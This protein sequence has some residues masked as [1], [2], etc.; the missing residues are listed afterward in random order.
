[1][2]HQYIEPVSPRLLLSLWRER[3]GKTR[4]ASS[5][6]PYLRGKV[7][8]W[9]NR[10][11][12]ARIWSVPGSN[13]LVAAIC[14]LF[15]GLLLQVRMSPLGQ[16]GFSIF[17]LAV[18]LYIRRFSGTFFTLMLAAMACMVSLRYL[19]WRFSATLDTRSTADFLL[20]LGFF[21]AELYLFLLTGMHVLKGIWPLTLPQQPMP[22]DT[23]EWP[24]VDVFIVASNSSIEIAN[25]TILA[26]LAMSWPKKKM[27]V[28]V[29]DAYPRADLQSLCSS[30]EVHYFASEQPGQDRFESVNQA[31]NQSTGDF[32][33]VLDGDQ[34]PQAKLLKQTMGWLVRHQSLGMVETPD[35]FLAP[36]LDEHNRMLFNESRDRLSFSITRRSMLIAA[37]GFSSNPVT[38]QRHTALHLQ[39]LGFGCA[40][41]G[42]RAGALPPQ[43]PDADT[44]MFC[45][46][47]P[48]NSIIL[49]WQKYLNDLVAAM[50]FYYP[51]VRLVFMT[52]PV[53]YLLTG[54]HIINTASDLWALY[55]L[56]HVL[57]G[58]IA[59]ARLN[60]GSRWGLFS[61]IRETMLAWYLLLPT[62]LTF[63]RTKVHQFWSVPSQTPS[64]SVK[65]SDRILA[66]TYG[67]I[68]W[69]NLSGLVV[70]S[71]FWFNS[72]EIPNDLTS[73][74]LLWSAFNLMRLAAMLC[75]TEEASAIQKYQRACQELPVMVKL[76]YG[77][78]LSC[79]TQNF[80]N[81]QLSIQ[82]P[83][84][85]ALPLESFVQIS[86]FHRRQESS[87]PAQ[88]VSLHE[89]TLQVRIDASAQTDYNA[90]AVAV[91]SRG[92]DWPKWLPGRH[93]DQPWP[94]W[95]SQSLADM[96]VFLAGKAARFRNL[97]QKWK[98]K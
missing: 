47:Q 90:L 66:I 41:V 80:P 76:P 38:K 56:P 92:L 7:N 75:V 39:A 55:A 29:L 91:F 20:S 64:N 1:M 95:L 26:S 53:A 33:L 8:H 83:T 87:F 65:P 37:G 42:W 24:S 59:L 73:L 85:L 88:I 43:N 40:Y 22:Q 89:Q 48:F 86:I 50:Q 78:S 70:G 54:L 82:L 18:A 30:S 17:L 19:N 12:H 4:V 10:L 71:W 27:I 28:Y 21:V 6:L 25:D 46:N 11:T 9:S 98:K 84:G 96:R 5:A 34:R 63:I 49:R 62:T 94:R 77:R 14:L 93:A 36:G 51:C 74:Y 44:E 81:T 13:V 23:H 16:F 31:L 72:N 68:G 52:A 3:W 32:I 67:L 57:L 69:L 15:F 45:V 2:G 97:I 58:Y 61:E 60:T 79:L 35:H